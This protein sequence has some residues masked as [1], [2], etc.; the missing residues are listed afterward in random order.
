VLALG[1]MLV[2]LLVVVEML[3]LQAYANVTAPRP[4]SASSRT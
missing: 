1:G 2:A 4:S 3:I